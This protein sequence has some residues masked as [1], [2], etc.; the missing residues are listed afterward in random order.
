M[1]GPVLL[2]LANQLLIGPLVSAATGPTSAFIVMNALRVL[3]IAL[4]GWRVI[5][6]KAGGLWSASWAGPAVLFFDHVVAKGG[7]MVVAAIAGVKDGWLAFG[8][9]LASYV[10]FAPVAMLPACAGAAAARR[11]SDSAQHSDAP[12]VPATPSV[13][14][15]WHRSAFR[16][17]ILIAV[18]AHMIAAFAAAPLTND[19]IK[20][21]LLSTP[22]I[23]AIIENL[24]EM[25]LSVL[26]IVGLFLFWRPARMLFIV[27]LALA[28]R[29]AAPAVVGGA[30]TPVAVLDIIGT[31]VDATLLG[32]SFS[33]PLAAQFGHHIRFRRV[34]LLSWLSAVALFLV[35]ILIFKLVGLPAAWKPAAS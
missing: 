32:V 31:S 4:A 24:G 29:A 28:I 30:A 10:M 33:P 12:A 21:S 20:D 23:L 11:H 8:G 9:V 19:S 5:R 35:L 27:P 6:A 7:V 16:F 34:V 13:K 2:A 17:G 18:A 1:R 15:Q 26:G 22:S 14:T 3:T 25:I